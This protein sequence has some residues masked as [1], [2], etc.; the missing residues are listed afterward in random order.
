[1]MR[2]TSS[3]EKTL[4]GFDGLGSCLIRR[5]SRMCPSSCSHERYLLTARASMF[6]VVIDSPRWR[7]D[8]TT[9]LPGFVIGV[10]ANAVNA[11]R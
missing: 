5:C 11:R 3:S 2:R 10:S 6:T 8:T 7:N 4:I 1:M 9:Q